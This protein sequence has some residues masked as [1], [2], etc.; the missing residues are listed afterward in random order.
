MKIRNVI[1]IIAVIITIIPGLH[2][3]FDEYEPSARAR[4]MG[5]TYCAVSDDAD[6]IFYNPAGLSLGQNQVKAGYTKIFSNDFQ[7]LTVFDASWDL[8][9][10]FGRIGFGYTGLDV[11][12]EGENLMSEKTFALGHSFTL[13]SD[14]HSQL[15]VGYT[16]NLY[17]LAIDRFSNTTAFGLNLGATAVLHTRTRLAF[18]VTNIN[19]PRVGEDEDHELPSE[20]TIGVSYIP[21]TGVTT[22]LDVKKTF[23]TPSDTGESST[24]IH[25]GVEATLF[26]I[27]SI[28]MGV[29]DD[30]TMY[31]AGVGIEVYKI[32]VE[33][34]YQMHSVLDDTHHV[35]IGFNF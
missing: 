10:N 11:D 32:L 14:V 19:N 28:R 22:T 27:L 3:I 35:G 18:A 23:N 24:E 21:Y 25:A 7:V 5:G 4:A 17:H 13:L 8:P 33:Y 30:P 2:G 29:Q 15:Y 20:M 16:A 34:A 6:A 9:K 1:G 26:D 12:Y 31:S